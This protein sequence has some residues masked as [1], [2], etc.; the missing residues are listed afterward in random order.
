MC[1]PGFNLTLISRFFMLSRLS[2]FVVC[3]TKSLFG[4]VWS[5]S[6]VQNII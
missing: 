1:D 5:I 4:V 3:G 6:N 2:D